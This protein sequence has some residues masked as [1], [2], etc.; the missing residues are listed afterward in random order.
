M[1][2]D[3]LF[4]TSHLGKSPSNNTIE[5]FDCS[6]STHPSVA[7]RPRDL[8]S[9]GAVHTASVRTAPTHAAHTQLAA[10]A[11]TMRAAAPA[12]AP[13]APPAPVCSP[14]PRAC[15]QH[16][17]EHA[18]HQHTQHQHA[19]RQ[20]LASR[21]RAARSTST[22]RMQHKPARIFPFHPQDGDREAKS[23]EGEP[24]TPHAPDTHTPHAHT[25]HKH[26]LH[27]RTSRRMR[28]HTR[29]MRMCRT[30]TVC[31]TRCP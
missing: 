28:T 18:Q 21:R 4:L 2:F 27:T 23:K 5:L 29:R 25:P 30:H 22:R 17:H 16:T 9:A 20:P 12:R 24:H 7:S 13:P 8:P 19:Q 3:W 11:R 26:A 10:L 15:T 1:L 6:N 31:S 14:A